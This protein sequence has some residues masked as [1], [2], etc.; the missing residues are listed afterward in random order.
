MRFV[1]QFL[2]LAAVLAAVVTRP[3]APHAGERGKGRTEVTSVLVEL[4]PPRDRDEERGKEVILLWEPAM[5][6]GTAFGFPYPDGRKAWEFTC[7]TFKVP[8]LEVKIDKRRTDE[9][10]CKLA[11]L[12]TGV[13]VVVLG[14]N[15]HKKLQRGSWWFEVHGIPPRPGGLRLL[16]KVHVLIEEDPAAP[17][18]AGKNA[19]PGKGSR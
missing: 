19:R 5:D 10:R 9:L 6:R 12:K 16:G 1:K 14:L 4:T 18:P 17:C 7:D 11:K 15:Y 2:A 8:G 13:T 3:A